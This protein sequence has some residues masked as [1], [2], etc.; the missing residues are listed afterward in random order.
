MTKKGGIILLIAMIFVMTIILSNTAFAA[1]ISGTVYDISLEKVD[2]AVVKIN[3]YPKQS[4]V[5]EEGFYEFTV[6]DGDYTLTAERMDAGT[7]TDRIEENI[8]VI[9][10][11]EF[12]LDLILF[13]DFSIEEELLND[14]D[15]E[16]DEPYLEPEKNNNVLWITVI[17]ALIL[18]AGF[19]HLTKVSF[20]K[21]KTVLEKELFYGETKTSGEEDYVKL[22]K[23]V[24]KKEGGRTTQK[25]IRKK[26]PLSEAKISLI[27]TELEASGEIKKIKKGRGNII[28]LNK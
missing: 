17:I 19:Y 5:A 21:V 12:N 16:L 14:M 2:S 4:M 20:K 8:T 18:I 24:I 6:P 13:P 23:D 1:T 22:V 7:V 10:E 15:I 9:G 3:T 28:I 27:I 26:V 11:G 25:D